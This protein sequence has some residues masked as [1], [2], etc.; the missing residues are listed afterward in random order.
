[1]KNEFK[2]MDLLKDNL[3]EYLGN[4]VNSE[5]KKYFKPNIFEDYEYDEDDNMLSPCCG[6][7]VD[8]DNMICPRCKE[9]V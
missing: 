5:N 6:E 1:M 8:Q 7:I 4:L 2:N 9:H 3:F